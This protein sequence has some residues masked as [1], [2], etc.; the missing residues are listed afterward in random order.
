MMDTD[1]LDDLLAERGWS[2]KDLAFA[3]GMRPGNLSRIING[4]RSPRPD[5][6]ARIARALGLRGESA[7]M[8]FDFERRR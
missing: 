8:I 7:A 5:S 6:R 1:R 2:R 3:A 4:K